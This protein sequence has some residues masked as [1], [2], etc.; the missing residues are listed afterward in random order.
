MAQPWLCPSFMYSL[1]GCSRALAVYF[2]KTPLLFN[3][4]LFSCFVFVILIN[5]GIRSHFH[6]P[7]TLF[8]PFFL[9]ESFLLRKGKNLNKTRASCFWNVILNPP[10]PFSSG[11][12]GVVVSAPQLQTFLRWSFS[13]WDARCWGKQLDAVDADGSDVNEQSV[14]HPSDTHT[15]TQ[16]HT[17]PWICNLRA[18]IHKAEQKDERDVSSDFILHTTESRRGEKPLCCFSVFCS[19][20]P[21][22]LFVCLFVAALI[23]LNV[24]CVPLDELRNPPLLWI[25]FTSVLKHLLRIIPQKLK[26]QSK[27]PSALWCSSLHQTKGEKWTR[28]TFNLKYF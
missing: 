12:G 28:H 18:L 20:L 17:L 21:F 6:L 10:K 4:F 13:C 19:F 15:H 5:A 26:Q 16:R 24:V 3:H 14:S 11:N 25:H 27:L 23:F 2:S 22:L 1:W 9:F 8:F 7:V